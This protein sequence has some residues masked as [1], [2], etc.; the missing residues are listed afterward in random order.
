MTLIENKV[1]MK[2]FSLDYLHKFTTRPSQRT[3]TALGVLPF[4]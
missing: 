4:G 2:T 1:M 3:D